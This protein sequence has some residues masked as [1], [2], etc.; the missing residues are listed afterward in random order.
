MHP[1][2][3]FVLASLLV[4][5]L[6]L[7]GETASLAQYPPAAPPPGYYP[8][9]GQPMPAYSPAPYQAAPMVYPGYHEHDGFYMR[10]VLGGGYLNTT[11]SVSGDSATLSGFAGSFAAAFGGTIAPNL[12]IY[13]EFSGM[14]ANEPK[15]SYGGRSETQRDLT[16]NMLTFGPGLAY[17]LQPMNVYFS[18]TVGFGYF[19]FSDNNDY[20]EDSES[21]LGFGFSTMVGKEWWVTTDWG[22]GVAGQFQMTTAK[23]EDMRLTGYGFALMF[24]ATYN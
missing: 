6:V 17:Y 10:L 23:Y 3:R 18:G 16:L 4:P 12:I 1:P 8:P 13:G 11:M 20:Y 7:L 21:D 2:L 22:M 14:S 24:S 15:M 5:A 19:N 9:P